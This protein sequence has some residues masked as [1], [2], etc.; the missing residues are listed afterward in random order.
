MKE[1]LI[2][3]LS[4]DNSF[5]ENRDIAMFEFGLSRE[6]HYDVL[7]VAPGWKPTKIMVD[8][9]VEIICTTDDPA[10]DLRYHIQLRN[11]GFPTKVLPTMRPDKLVNIDKEEFWVLSSGALV[12]RDIF[13]N[14]GD[15]DIAVTIKG[16]EQLKENYNL[17]EKENGWYIVNDKVE[18]VCDGNKEELKYKP[19]KLDC[20]YFAQNIFEYLEYLKL[21]SREKDIARIPLVESY[22]EKLKQ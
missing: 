12:L 18:C 9:D 10:D 13:E 14:A 8:Y 6:K 15:L 16:L 7:V 22:I 19:E 17:I 11:M 20:G 4:A 21:S 5:A 3:L 2:Q 1:R